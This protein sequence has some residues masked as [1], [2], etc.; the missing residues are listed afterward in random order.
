[1]AP[2]AELATGEQLTILASGFVAGSAVT[3]EVHSTVVTLAHTTAAADGT[4]SVHVTLPD[5]LAAGAHTLSLVGTTGTAVFRFTIG[6]AIVAGGTDRPGTTSG[7]GTGALSDT[8]ADVRTGVA[9]GVLA[10][11]LGALALMASARRRVAPRPLILSVWWP[12]AVPAI[13]VAL[14]LT[15]AGAAAA[16]TQPRH[17]TANLTAYG[18]DDRRLPDNP[19]LRAAD[20]VRLVVTG[21]VPDSVVTVSGPASVALRTQQADASGTV[22]LTYVVPPHLPRGQHL[23]ALT[24]PPPVRSTPGHAAGGDLV[25]VIPVIGLFPYRISNAALSPSPT[26]SAGGGSGGGGLSTTGVRITAAIVAA[27]AALT[28][29]ALA[30]R[31]GRRRRP[32][33]DGRR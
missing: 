17:P 21:F 32:G 31:L 12:F 29:G 10:L 19:V 3:V 25:A 5:A 15:G 20:G 28:V 16:A 7:S 14:T 24:G 23:V 26:P 6:D 11:A 33:P 13:L 4:L 22:R 2:G 1:V 18:R 27:L 8:G 9:F 30:L